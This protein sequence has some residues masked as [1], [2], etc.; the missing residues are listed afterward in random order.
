M[1]H[2]QVQVKVESKIPTMCT[3]RYLQLR[4]R[5]VCVAEDCLIYD[6]QVST[7]DPT[8]TSKEERRSRVPQLFMS[9]DSIRNMPKYFTDGI[10]SSF[11][12]TENSTLSAF[13]AGAEKYVFSL[14]SYKLIFNCS[15]WIN[16][17][18][19][20]LIKCPFQIIQVDEPSDHR[21]NLC[22]KIKPHNQQ[23]FLPLSFSIMKDAV[24]LTWSVLQESE[25]WI[26]W[27]RCLFPWKSQL[28]DY[29]WSGH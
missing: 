22:Q 2:W 28:K 26:S 13:F 15:L 5:V 6:W 3:E 7:S 4:I 16:N 12:P 24:Y 9:I 18:N 27:V 20:I 19:I 14:Y 25:G 17:M 21:K 11:S 10:I 29:E 8:C 23:R 1:R